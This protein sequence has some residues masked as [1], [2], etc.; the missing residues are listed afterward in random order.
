MTANQEI[1]Y[2]LKNESWYNYDEKTDEYEL[3]D[4]ATERVRNSFKMYNDLHAKRKAEG[5]LCI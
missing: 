5:S 2:W 1:M 3:T 4:K